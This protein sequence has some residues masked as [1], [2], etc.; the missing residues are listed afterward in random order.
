MTRMSEMIERVARA[1]DPAAFSYDAIRWYWELWA[2]KR[3]QKARENAAA[4]IEAMREPTDEMVEEGAG[5]GNVRV[6]WSMMIDEAL[7]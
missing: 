5:R 1:I 4:A 2:E 7:K 3:Q 6:T